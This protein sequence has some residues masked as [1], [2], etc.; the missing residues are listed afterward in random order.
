M[1][2][3][4]SEI[5]DSI[6]FESTLTKE[7]IEDQPPATKKQKEDAKRPQK[8]DGN[9][10]FIGLAVDSTSLK[11]FRLHGVELNAKKM[12]DGK[13]NMNA[14]KKEVAVMT[15]LPHNA[16]FSQDVFWGSEHDY[17]AFKRNFK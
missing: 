16:L 13:N 1:M 7:E 10:P 8:L 14:L 9:F 6:N 15:T 4:D 17:S 12:Y 11:M 3:N 2:I 5:I